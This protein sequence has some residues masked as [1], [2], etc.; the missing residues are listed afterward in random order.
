MGSSWWGGCCGPRAA[1][2]LTAACPMEVWLWLWVLVLVM[3]EAAGCGLC[4]RDGG[5]C[6]LRCPRG[7]FWPPACET[8]R[9]RV[10]RWARG[11]CLASGLLEGEDCV[12]AISPRLLFNLRLAWG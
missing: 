12:S 4:L 3:G 1:V 8:V 11:W 6:V 2:D 9:S 10:L 5:D 7:D